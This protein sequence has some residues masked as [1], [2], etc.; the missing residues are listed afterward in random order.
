M[1]IVPNHREREFMQRLRARGWVKASQ[2]PD[3]K[4]TL[5]HLLE[6]RW[7]ERRGHGA[8][9]FYRITEEGFAASFIGHLPLLPGAFPDY[10]APVI[11]DDAGVRKMVLMR[12]GMPPPP[13][14]PG[15]PVTNI[16]NTSSPHWRACL[17]PCNSFESTRRSRP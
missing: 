16:R 3:A 15:P 6:K 12:W 4:I 17:V 7:I 8:D 1:Q 2:I 9:A 14:T 5:K 13:P 11:R 10:L